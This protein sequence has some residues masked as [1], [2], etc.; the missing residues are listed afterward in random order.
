MGQGNM[1]DSRQQ[2]QPTPDEAVPLPPELRARANGQLDGR[3]IIAWAEFDL[4]SSNRFARQFA[5]LTEQELIV[6][7]ADDKSETV[8]IDAIEEAKVLE[9]LGVHRLRLSIRNQPA[10]D[11]RFTNRHRR[12]MSRLTRKLERRL[13]RKTGQEDAPPEWLDVAERQTEL[14]NLCPRCGELIPA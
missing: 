10:M 1:S 12:D 8:R 14:S 5:M 7:I 11:L 3:Q 9:G 4:D 6:L 13:P 2:Q